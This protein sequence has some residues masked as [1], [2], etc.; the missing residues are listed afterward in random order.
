MKKL[1]IAVLVLGFA[2]I[3]FGTLTWRAYAQPGWGMMGYWGSNSTA[4]YGCR[5]WGSS[6]PTYEWWYVR[7]STDDQQ[8]ADQ[9]L[10]EKMALID[11]S[12]LT[13]S[14]QRTELEEIQNDIIVAINALN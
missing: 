2:L 4:T 1:M 8:L 5:G 6:T 13:P 3:T 7:L 10:I 9:L 11:W 12:S 14:E